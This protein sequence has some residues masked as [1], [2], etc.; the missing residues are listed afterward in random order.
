MH[1]KNI[2]A[3]C[4]SIF[5][6][7]LIASCSEDSD[8]VPPNEV[9]GLSL[10]TTLGGEGHKV[11]LY[12]AN[13]KLQT[14]YNEIFFQIKNQDG[15]LVSNANPTWLPLMYMMNMSHSCPFSEIT[16]KDGA[17]STYR[18]YI[19]FQMAGNE[20]EY[21]ELSVSYTV[22]GTSYTAKEKIQVAAASHRIVESFQGSDDKRYVLALV[23]PSEP[24][25]AT[26]DMTAVLY[27]MKSMMEFEPVNN[28]KI[29]IDPRMPGMGNHGS[30]NNVDLTQ[31]TDKMYKGKLSL[32]MTGYWKVNLQVEDASGTVLKGEEI[33]EET[34]S[35]SIYFEVE[36]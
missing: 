25:V 11:E 4:A 33:T 19:V 7:F 31:D 35:S 12:T 28:Y 9:D 22:G 15:S 10:V 27:S 20:M 32:T 16:K 36:F 5:T 34:E 23:E 29:K 14:G 1:F 21:W 3:I 24:R 18:G 6:L 13:G 2:L 8:P 30:P 17:Q 26:N